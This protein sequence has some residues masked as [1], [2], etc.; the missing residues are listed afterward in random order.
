MTVLKT[1]SKPSTEVIYYWCALVYSNQAGILKQLNNIKQVSSR[2]QLNC[3]F[4]SLSPSP[5]ASRL[6]VFLCIALLHF[7]IALKAHSKSI[8]LLRYNPVDPFLFLTALL[9]RNRLHIVF[10]SLAFEEKTYNPLLSRLQKLFLEFSL[11][12]SGQ[13]V[14]LT[15]EIGIFYTGSASKFIVFSNSYDLS[16]T[17]IIKHRFVSAKSTVQYVSPSSFT[18]EIIFVASRFSQWQGLDI[19]LRAVSSTASDFALHIVGELDGN[20]LNDNRVVYHHILSAKDLE[21]LYSKAHL[22]LSCFALHRKGMSEACP[23]KVREYLAYGIPVYSGHKDC[24]PDS[25][26]FYQCGKADFASIL[27]YLDLV[28]PFTRACVIESARPYVDSAILLPRL[29]NDIVS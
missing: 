16:A 12:F 18:P 19:I 23:L 27:T 29:L 17:D 25:F 2:L 9:F 11:F 5:K 10:H 4:L 14:A 3:R 28:K 6:S 15:N 22:G 8:F 7:K 21:S 24:F 26:P 13:P 1:T 20:I